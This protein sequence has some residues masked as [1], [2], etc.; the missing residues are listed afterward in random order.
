MSKYGSLRKAEGNS[1]FFLTRTLAEHDD[2]MEHPL[3]EKIYKK[4]ITLD[5]YKCYLASQLHTFRALDTAVARQATEVPIAAVF[6]ENIERTES[7]ERDLDYLCQG[8][9]WAEDPALA[10]SPKTAQYLAQLARDS[11]PG[12]THQLLCHHFLQYN[13]ILSGGQ[14]LKRCMNEKFA[15]P[16]ANK[17]GVSFFCFD[18]ISISK[19]AG[20]VQEYCRKLDDLSL[21]EVQRTDMLACM[22]LIYTLILEMFDE[23][24]ARQPRAEETA[25]EW[26]EKLEPELTDMAI[27][28]LHAYDG[29]A[30]GRILMSIRGRVLDVSSAKDAY[31]AKGNYHLF[32]GHDVTKSLTTMS[33]EQGDLDDLSFVP[34]HEDG[35]QALSRWEARLAKSY[36]VVGSIDGDTRSSLD[37][38]PATTPPAPAPAAAGACPFSGATSGA[39]GEALSCPFGFG[40]QEKER[41]LS[42]S[43][44]RTVQKEAPS[45]VAAAECPWPFVMLHDPLQGG[46]RHLAKN[47]ALVAAVVGYAAMGLDWDWVVV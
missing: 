2:T 1:K 38:S 18:S 14:Y 45:A 26:K 39:D 28:A 16:V 35:R 13:A 47:V 46:T 25:V 17:E 20:Y 5:E 24:A 27:A 7:L 8:G 32:A 4:A 40:A 42:K 36:T 41:S 33:L 43:P 30:N 15:K 44:I 6:D 23:G 3:M 22:K 37:L 10:P 34:Q 19:Q 12:R 31:G 21:D 11:Q 29:G 9:D